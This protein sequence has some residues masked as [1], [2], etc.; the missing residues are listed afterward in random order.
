MSDQVE[1]RLVIEDEDAFCE[2]IALLLLELSAHK[3][4][5]ADVG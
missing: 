1:I 2:R 4:G 5:G 3:H